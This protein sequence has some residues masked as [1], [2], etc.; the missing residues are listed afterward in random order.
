MSMIAYTRCRVRPLP[1]GQ[2]HV[3]TTVERPTALSNI[4]IMIAMTALVVGMIGAMVIV[5]SV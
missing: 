5:A 4:A 3:Q 1:V 2:A